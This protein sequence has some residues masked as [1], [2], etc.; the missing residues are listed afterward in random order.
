VPAALARV[1]RD[2]DDADVH[3]GEGHKQ[4]DEAQSSVDAADLAS[5]DVT[6]NV[7]T[8]QH[9]SNCLTRR[10]PKADE[11]GDEDERANRLPGRAERGG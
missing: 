3:A 1:E 6:D 7:Q 10:A 9:H 8:E 11:I 2:P 4:A 5:V